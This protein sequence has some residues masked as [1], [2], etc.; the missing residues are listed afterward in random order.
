MTGEAKVILGWDT[1]VIRP[2][3]E[4]A[5]SEG[6]CP[7]CLVR[8]NDPVYGSDGPVLVAAT[9]CPSCGHMFMLPGHR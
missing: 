4:P 1:A 2:D 3:Q 6:F 9:V 5:L 8:L 7:E